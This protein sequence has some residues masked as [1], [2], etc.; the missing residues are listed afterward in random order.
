MRLSKKI[1]QYFTLVV[2]CSM[3][4]GFFIFYFAVERAT[5]Q[6]AIGKLEKLS[7]V[8]EKKNY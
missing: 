3:T 1:T 7:N 6:S 2:F 8:V 5:T 4:F